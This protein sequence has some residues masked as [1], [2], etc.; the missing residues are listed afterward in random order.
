VSWKAETEEKR[1]SDDEGE[2]GG[3]ERER[4]LTI[5]R[6]GRDVDDREDGES[7]DSTR[8]KEDLVVVEVQLEEPSL[9]MLAFDWRE[10]R[11]GRQRV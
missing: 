9:E 10:K 6:D 11:A 5:V 4:R 8:P 7:A 1:V 3:R 2:V